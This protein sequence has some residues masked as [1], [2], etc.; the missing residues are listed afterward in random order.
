MSFLRVA[1]ETPADRVGA[2]LF[3]PG[4]PGGDGIPVALTF[5]AL[6][7]GDDPAD[8]VTGAYKRMWGTGLGAPRCA[9]R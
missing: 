9:R 3:N 6:W 1:A 7:T 4:G 5:A 8:P 2:I